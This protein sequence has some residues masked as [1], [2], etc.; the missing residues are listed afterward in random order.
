MILSSTVRSREIAL[1]LS[2]MYISYLK[3]SK[4]SFLKSQHIHIVHKE[5]RDIN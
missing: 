3:T 4:K 1:S 5:Q 2:L